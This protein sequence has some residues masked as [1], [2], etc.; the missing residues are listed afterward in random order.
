MATAAP[1]R[2]RATTRYQRDT[3][4][5]RLTFPLQ[6][7]IM[8]AVTVLS[9]AATLWLGLSGLKSDV[10]DIRTRMEMATEISTR[11][12]KLLEERLNAVRETVTTLTRE[13]RMQQLEVAQLKESILKMDSGMM[14]RVTP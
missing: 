6:L 8:V 11:D 10:R 3:D 7:V 2:R 5:S 13:Q 12:A 9:C 1:R 4:A 14:R